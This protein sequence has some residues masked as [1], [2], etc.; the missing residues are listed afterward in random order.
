MGK[1]TLILSA[2]LLVTASAFGVTTKDMSGGVTA[3]EIVK[4]LTGAGITITNVKVTGAPKAIGTFTG[5]SADGVG[6]D[7][8]VIM[9]SGN[10]STAA[11]PNTSPGTTGAL[12][13]PGDTGLD[14]LVKPRVTHDAVVLE[15]DAVTTT[16]TFSIRYVFASEEYTEYVGS[17]FND[18]FAFFVD[19]ANIALVPGTAQP[20]AV[21]S[22]NHI[23]NKGLYNDNPPNSAKFG[24]SFD[25]FTTVLTAVAS[26]S[27]GLSHHIRLAIADTTDSILDSAVYLAEGGISGTGVAAAVVPS[28]EPFA[29]E[30]GD[31]PTA[32]LVSNLD[33][34]DIPVTVYGV[35]EG[36]TPSL[37]GLGL[38]DDSTVTFKLVKKID[39]ATYSYLMHVKI[40]PDTPAGAYPLEVRAGLNGFDV[41]GDV[42]L[43][44][45]CA[46]PFILSS[47]GHQPASTSVTS[48]QTANLTV[49]PT[50]T[51]AYRYQWYLGHSGNTNF[52]IAGATTATLKTPAITNATEFWVRVSNPCGST[53]SQTATVTTR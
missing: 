12:A 32:L 9:S 26:V 11:G 18:V 48:G 25:G 13:T 29:D 15:F 39:A 19:G 7:S 4:T 3:D 28:L 20:V 33:E 40:G 23:T 45:D 21:N 16:S 46:P 10:V 1:R 44:V 34:V 47:P 37:A 31:V 36:V 17:P 2:M 6:I 49:S 42:L 14:A 50:G 5:G 43:V 38:P 41:F 24:T 30:N 22:I 8:G 53:D 27:S 52:P 51:A 35:P